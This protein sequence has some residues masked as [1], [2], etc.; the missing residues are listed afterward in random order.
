[1]TSLPAK[2]MNLADYGIAV[3]N[4]AD[5]VVL[6][7]ADPVSAVSELASPLLAMKRGRISFSR[8]AAVINWPVATSALAAD[9]FGAGLSIE[10]KSLAR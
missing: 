2:L 7:C 8:P 4:P 6:D 5:I 3:G 1:V 10:A 9:D